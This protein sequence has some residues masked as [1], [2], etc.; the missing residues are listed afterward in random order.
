MLAT[1]CAGSEP[2]AVARWTTAAAPAVARS[3]ATGPSASPANRVTPSRRSSAGA[4]CGRRTSARTRRPEPTRRAVRWRPRKPAA[5]VPTTSSEEAG[6]AVDGDG[7]VR[8]EP[9][10]EAPGEGAPEREG[11]RRR[12]A[13]GGER[14]LPGVVKEDARREFDRRRRHRRDVAARSEQLDEL[15][16]RVR[17]LLEDDVLRRAEH[18]M[19]EVAALELAQRDREAGEDV[20][21]HPEL[22]SRNNTL[23][24]EEAGMKGL[25]LVHAER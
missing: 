3:T 19:G 13:L 1:T 12:P 18:P 2:A 20:V 21:G 4:N 9:A 14:E 6:P 15:R 11:E 7:P 23:T 25:V 5:P 16:E 24:R 8:A 17:R 22:S 10:Q